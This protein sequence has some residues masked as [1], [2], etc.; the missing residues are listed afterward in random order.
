MTQSKKL[1]RKLNSFERRFFRAPTSTISIVARVK[2]FISEEDLRIALNKVRQQH[3]LVGAR[4]YL[5][6]NYD[7]WYTSENVPVNPFR[8]IQRKSDKDWYHELLNDYKIRFELEKGPLVRFVLLQSPEISE[9]IIICHHAICDGTSLAILAR[10]LLLYIGNPGRETQELSEPPLATLENFPTNVTIGKAIMFAINTM[11]KKWQN[12][13]VIFDEED[14]DNIFRAYWDSFNFNIISVELNEKETSDLVEKCHQQGVTVNSALNTAFLAARRSIR[15]PFKGGRQNILLP[16]N[17]R[18]RYRKPVG[19]HFGLY[20]AG[21]QFKLSYNP[22]KDFWENAKTF[23]NKVREKLNINKVFKFA[24]ITSLIDKTLVDARSF[25]FMGKNVPSN[26]SRYEKIHAFSNDEKNIVN[27]RAKKQIPSMPGLAVTNLGQL[28]YPTKY[29]SLELDR[30]IFI[31]SGTPYIEL[32]IPAVTV[33]GK[34]T[35]TINYLEETTDTPTMERIKNKAL[36]YLG[37]AK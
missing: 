17:T 5:D 16:V 21:F 24:A 11:N 25:S 28:D 23:G 15:G 33:A 26:F 22:K 9:I 29:G 32:V 10:D 3:P 1:K 35:F 4:I 34:L 30:F 37:L 12:V 7:A 14:E 13:K 6:E 27:K 2:G 19:E 31:T 36:E 20:I 8:V 18:K